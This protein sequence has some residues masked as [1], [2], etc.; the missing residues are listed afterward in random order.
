[1]PY[2]VYELKSDMPLRAAL[3]ALEDALEPRVSGRLSDS[4]INIPGVEVL[5][6]PKRI[7]MI[8]HGY[9]I[10]RDTFIYNIRIAR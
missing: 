5:A 2:Q 1:M 6:G 9:D 4:D 8:V 10:M 7:A 3:A